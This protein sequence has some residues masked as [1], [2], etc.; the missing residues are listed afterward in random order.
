[1]NQIQ[2]GFI[3]KKAPLQPYVALQDAK[4]SRKEWL[5]IKNYVFFGLGFAPVWVVMMHSCKHVY[6]DLCATYHFG[7]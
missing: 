5:S 1:M 6:H 2:R 3:L 7:T 4:K